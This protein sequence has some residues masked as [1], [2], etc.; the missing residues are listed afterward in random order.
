MRYVFK[1]NVLLINFNSSGTEIALDFFFS[2]FSNCLII[3]AYN[4]TPT[5]YKTAVIKIFYNKIQQS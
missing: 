3:T 4:K 5:I 1:L 2:I